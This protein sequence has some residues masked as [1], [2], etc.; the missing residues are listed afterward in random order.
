MN[1]STSV[2]SSTQEVTGQSAF[3]VLITLAVAA[4]CQPTHTRIDSVIF[5][6]SISLTRA[7]PSVCLWDG[8]S[9]ACTLY[10][11]I[12]E[13]RATRG[14][15]VVP[16]TRPTPPP[17]E[18]IS[19][20]LT[21]NVVMVKLLVAFVGVLPQTIK[22]FSMRGIPWTQFAAA[23]FFFAST[24]RLI[25]ELSGLENNRYD[26]FKKNEV[27]ERGTPVSFLAYLVLIGQC[28]SWVWI[29]YNIGFVINI[30]LSGHT[31][32]RAGEFLI[33][34]VFIIT[35]IAQFVVTFRGIVM[36]LNHSEPE[37]P[38]LDSA[39][40]LVLISSFKC[41]TTSPADGLNASTFDKGIA[42]FWG[43]TSGVLLIF[44]S[45]LLGL[46]L[47]SL[48]DF[49][50]R[51]IAERSSGQDLILE[52]EEV[53]T[54]ESR[55]REE[56]P[57]GRMADAATQN[58]PESGIANRCL[59]QRIRAALMRLICLVVYIIHIINAGLD[60]PLMAFIRMNS[61]ASNIVAFTIVNLVITVCYYLVRFDG[62][63]T[64]S[65]AWTSVLG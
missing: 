7:F 23:I 11:A 36:N 1:S 18:R 24:L 6:G 50:G 3:W 47:C 32:L 25:V 10:K 15:D 41:L 54:S 28:C 17:D 5:G 34:Y 48:L 62:T 45:T 27:T 46:L 4:V 29:W 40:G 55:E 65:P 19:V 30:D 51:K 31:Y 42:K 9:D 63:G 57:T 33:E 20:R 43:L 2:T 60:R 22:I 58:E 52:R 13:R 12:H 21:P 53:T 26:L 44:Y 49:L 39:V 16:V 38:Q 59:G 61:A 35:M 37:A 56:A 64:T 8:I 14:Q